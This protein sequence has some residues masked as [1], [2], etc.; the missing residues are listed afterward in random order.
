[1]LARQRPAVGSIPDSENVTI[2][3]KSL[4]TRGVLHRSAPWQTAN[5]NMGILR[6]RLE[7][8]NLDAPEGEG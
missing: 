8:K 6:R 1:M 3:Y 4:L 7:M 2:S 5:A